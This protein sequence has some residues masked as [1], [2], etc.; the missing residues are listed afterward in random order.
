MTPPEVADLIEA[1]A[2]QVRGRLL[3]RDVERPI[4][5][6][7]HTGGVW[8]AQQ[9]HDKLGIVEPLGTLDI[10][11]Y[12]DDFSRIGMNP[13]V[14]PS[15]LPVPIDGRHVL[16]VDDVLHTGRTVRAALNELFDYGRPAS[17]Q[18][19]A[20]IERSGRELPIQA[21]VFGLSPELEPGEHI[22]LTGPHPLGLVVGTESNRSSR[23]SPQEATP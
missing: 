23:K 6:G 1:L 20:L 14:R 11:F 8:L 9:L 18:L 7:I 4:M 13:E 10:S 22:T 19:V 5:V 3:A 17:V 2:R 16:L 12:R 15:D 21:D